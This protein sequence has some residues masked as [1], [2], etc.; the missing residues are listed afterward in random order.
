MGRL[1]PCV[2]PFWVRRHLLGCL[3]ARGTLGSPQ[4]SPLF[5]L[6]PI[7]GASSGLSPPRSPSGAS[8]FSSCP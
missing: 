8:S 3:R 6:T 7:P 4:S 2:H 1:A 5:S